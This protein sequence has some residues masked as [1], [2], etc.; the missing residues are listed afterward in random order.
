VDI[1]WFRQSLANCG[2][3]IPKD[4]A[5]HLPDLLWFFQMGAIY[6]W[7][8]D[9]SPKQVNS[10]RLLAIATRS[11]TALIRISALP[12]MRPVRKAVLQAFQ[13]VKGTAS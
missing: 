8:I 9:E 11:I 13:I 2:M 10:E 5:A 12:L 7:V 1:A 6:F 3:R 4:L